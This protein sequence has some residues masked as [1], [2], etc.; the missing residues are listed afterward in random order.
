[1]I[2]SKGT[3]LI[4]LHW[5]ALLDIFLGLFLACWLW[6]SIVFV[7]IQFCK[8]ITILLLPKNLPGCCG[9][10]S[11]NVGLISGLSDSDIARPRCG[12]CW[13]KSVPR[14]CPPPLCVFVM[15][16]KAE[17]GARNLHWQKAGPRN[18]GSLG[19]RWCSGATDVHPCSQ[20]QDWERSREEKCS[21]TFV[22]G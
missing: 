10:R 2:L 22:T 15:H 13:F 1:M 21:S 6:G 12:R 4:R 20:Q 16:S 17:V 8:L 3:L 19:R 7:S 5:H 14:P 18:K 9:G 11:V